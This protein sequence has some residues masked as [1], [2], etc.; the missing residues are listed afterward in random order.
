MTRS[1]LLR[2]TT[3]RAGFDGDAVRTERVLRPEL[4][5]RRHASRVG[6]RSGIVPLHPGHIYPIGG[7]MSATPEISLEGGFPSLA[8]ATGWLNSQPLTPAGLAGKVVL[9][10][11][12]TYTC[13]NWLRTEPY[14]RGWSQAYRDDG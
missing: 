8:G 10:D 1:V 14:V 2:S 5:K 13:I 11:F 4:V 9:V 7:P 6:A 12:W 3:S